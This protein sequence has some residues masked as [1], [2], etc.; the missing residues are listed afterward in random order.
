MLELTTLLD[1]CKS[2]LNVGWVNINKH[3]KQQHL[4]LGDSWEEK[5]KCV[6]LSNLF[7]SDDINL[8]RFLKLKYFG[9]LEQNM[10]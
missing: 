5:I 6:N 1:H 9:S 3:K 7:G 2:S 4:L 10:N 8:E